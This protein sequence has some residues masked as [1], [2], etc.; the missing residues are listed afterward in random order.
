MYDLG[1]AQRGMEGFGAH[2]V[3][4]TNASHCAVY[5]SARRAP[6]IADRRRS[7]RLRQPLTGGATAPH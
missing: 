5:P 3:W 2:D 6:V 7:R 1:K 4:T